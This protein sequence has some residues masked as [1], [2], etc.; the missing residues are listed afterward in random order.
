M[1]WEIVSKVDVATFARVTQD[2][3]RDVWYT[4][5]LGHIE[6]YTGWQK[7]TAAENI[8]EYVDGSGDAI[9]TPRVPINTVTT[10]QVHG[11]PLPSGY[12]AST[13]DGIRLRSYRPGESF[14]TTVFL[15]RTT[16]FGEIFPFGLSNIYLSYNVGGIASLP[17]EYSEAVKEALLLVIKEFSVVPRMEGSDSMLKKYRPDRTMVPEEVLHNYGLHGKIN[18]I[19]RAILPQTKT[20]GVRS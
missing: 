18:G 12:W 9:L 3:L 19:L 13:W 10:I 8:T 6:R 1:A 16:S 11:T 14:E 7:L 2:M 20:Y 17:V 4:T 5:A 15:E